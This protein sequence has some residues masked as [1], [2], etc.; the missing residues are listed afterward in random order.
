MYLKD[1]RTGVEY[2][3]NKAYQMWDGKGI[4]DLTTQKE[5]KYANFKLAL[6]LYAIKI[7]NTTIGDY[8]QIEERLWSMQQVNGGITSLANL[9]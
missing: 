8:T 4:Y 1:N 7:F 3:F 6:I 5:G 2:Y 9:K